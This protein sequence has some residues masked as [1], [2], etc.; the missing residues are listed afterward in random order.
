MVRDPYATEQPAL[1]DVLDALDDPECRAIIACLS[2]PMTAKE[3]SN[4]CDVPLSTTYRKLELLSDASLLEERTELRASG[5][6][7]AR[8]AVDFAAVHVALD[9][10][11]S[12]AVTIEEPER[13]PDEQLSELWAEVKKR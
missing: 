13:T 11:R 5:R 10:D 2:E 7:T 12:L 3:I 6:H 4:R 8:Y 1:Q 9:E